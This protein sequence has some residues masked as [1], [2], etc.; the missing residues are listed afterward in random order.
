[1]DNEEIRIYYESLEQGANFILPILNGFIAK[2]G[3][4]LDTKLIKLKKSHGNY[5]K[6][7]DPIIFWKDP[8]ILISIVKNG[9]EYPLII[10]LNLPFLKYLL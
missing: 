7:I 9:K 3:L 10:K 8:D 1:M 2:H 6:E 4:K 5:A